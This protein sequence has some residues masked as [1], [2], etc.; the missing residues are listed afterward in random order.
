[1]NSYIRSS[2]KQSQFFFR[3]VNYQYVDVKHKSQ[4]NVNRNFF[5]YGKTLVMLLFMKQAS[6]FWLLVLSWLRL[7]GL[8][9]R[10]TNSPV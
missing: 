4:L 2:N 1:M 5:S 7:T 3:V 6:I 10:A 9:Y 8:I